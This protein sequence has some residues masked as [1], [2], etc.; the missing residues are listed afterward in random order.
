MSVYSSIYPTPFPFLSLPHSSVSVSTPQKTL[1]SSECLKSV[2]PEGKVQ[3][4]VR[5]RGGRAEEEGERGR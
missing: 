5:D 1:M 4:G 3:A 2:G